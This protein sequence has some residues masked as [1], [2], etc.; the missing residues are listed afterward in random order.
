M[1]SQY[2]NNTKNT[3]DNLNDLST[4]KTL[5]INLLSSY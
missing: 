5:I 4:Y 1:Y 3:I 2:V